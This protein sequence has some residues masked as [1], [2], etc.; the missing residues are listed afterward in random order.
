MEISVLI[1]VR[2]NEKYIEMCIDSIICQFDNLD[3][4]WELLI[5]DGE[6]DDNTR[7]LAEK[8]LKK[9]NVSWKIYNNP[10][11][12]LAKGWNI[13]ILKSRGKYI[14][15]P[16]AHSRLH[17]SYIRTAHECLKNMPEDVAAVGGVLNTKGSGYWGDIIKQALSTPV[18]VGNSSFRTGA[19]SGFHDTAVYALYRKDIFDKTGMFKTQLIRHQDTEF[20]HRAK[21]AG[22]RFYLNNNMQADYYC[23]DSLPELTKQMYRNG[24]YF[25]DVPQSLKFRHL[26]PMLFFTGIVALLLAGLVFTPAL[27]CGLGMLCIYLISL[28]IIAVTTSIKLKN[29]KYLLMS[30]VIASMHLYYAMGTLAGIM[31]KLFSRT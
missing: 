25:I 13:G 15:R 30:L 20:H 27:I 4:D 9:S 14:I 31:K 2:N 18:G 11:L 23:R 7:T 6:S 12:L 16:D 10:G 22:Y 3:I 24:L 29:R 28:I 8:K 19:S 26:A 5:I 17:E 21:K 1:V